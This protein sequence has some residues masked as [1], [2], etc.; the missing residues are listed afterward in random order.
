MP[1]TQDVLTQVDSEIL[2]ALPRET[3]LK[4]AIQRVRRDHQPALPRSKTDLEKI[5][6]R[7]S[8]INGENW[9]LFVNISDANNNRV[10]IFGL[11][12]PIRNMA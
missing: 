8:H 12:E 11:Q 6:D 10:I 5:P 2:V 4:C 7:Y 3:S 1:V 9:V